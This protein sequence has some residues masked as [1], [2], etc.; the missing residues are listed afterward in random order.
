MPDY[1]S[2]DHPE[3][4]IHPNGYAEDCGEESRPLWH[5]MVAANEC[6]CR[7]SKELHR[8]AR[9]I[10]GQCI[11]AKA[12]P[13]AIIHIRVA[14][15]D[16]E[17]SEFCDG[18]FA[19]AFMARNELTRKTA[20]GFLHLLRHLSYEGGS[21]LD[22]FNHSKDYDRYTSYVDPNWALVQPDGF[23]TISGYQFPRIRCRRIC[24][25]ETPLSENL[26]PD[27]GRLFSHCHIISGLALNSAD[28]SELL[29]GI[30]TGIRNKRSSRGVRVRELEI[31]F[32][33]V[34]AAVVEA[35]IRHFQSG[36]SVDL[37]QFVPSV[38]FHTGISPDEWPSSCPPWEEGVPVQKEYGVTRE[39]SLN[40]TTSG[41]EFRVRMFKDHPSHESVDS[42]SLF[43][44]GWQFS[45]RK[46][47][48]CASVCFTNG[49]ISRRINI[50]AWE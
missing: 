34:S 47:S 45:S 18:D 15:S 2:I 5:E 19:F 26:L 12:G 44:G 31:E 30:L 3:P 28:G 16:S 32:G 25:F 40:N 41:Q 22:Y 6:P 10:A 50:D 37:R 38:L 43:F 17:Q 36:E 48:G 7:Q 49:D 29:N 23:V 39:F 21:A 9:R 42:L 4:E 14:F 13:E 8:A 35:L 33:Y 27:V 1:G 20:R 24:S 46:S 11:T